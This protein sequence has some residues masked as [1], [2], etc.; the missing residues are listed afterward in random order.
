MFD[1]MVL[2][3]ANMSAGSAL[4]LGVTPYV[5]GVAVLW[6]AA[7][8]TF[9]ISLPLGLAYTL[10]SMQL[11]RTG[12]DYVW[13]S[14]KLSPKLSVPVA[15]A[16][17]FNM[18]TY[19][20]LTSYFW[21]SSFEQILLVMFK[22]D[23]LGQIPSLGAVATYLVAAIP[24]MFLVA[25]NVRRPSAVSRLNTYLSIIACFAVA[26]GTLVLY[27]KGVSPLSHSFASTFSLV[28]RLNGQPGFSGTLEA[29][30][31]L[32]AFSFIW[33]FAGPAVA[34]EARDRKALK[35]NVL[36]SQLLT[37]ALIGVPFYLM[38]GPVSSSLFYTGLYNFWTLAMYAAGPGA[39]WILAI[40]LIAW[41]ILELSMGILVFSR[42]ILAM[43]L[44]RLLPEL[45]GQINSRG[46][47]VPAHLLDLLLTLSFLSVPL[48][49]SVGVLALYD[50]LPLSL[51]YMGLV[52]I[53]AT[54][55]SG[56]AVKF[57]GALSLPLLSYLGWAVIMSPYLGL[58][59]N[60]LWINL[61][62]LV[63]LLGLGVSIY[64][65]ARV[66][67]KKIGVQLDRIYREVPPS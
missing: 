42:Y 44:D 47:P 31:L 55:F 32:S 57:A 8:V 21:S 2:N 12:G 61:V 62:Y 20:A 3:L 9:L 27:L 40:G 24:F 43:A 18:P 54:K 65:R 63:S 58:R 19:F 45:L 37:L 64:L 59:G 38:K 52:A 49:S 25:I 34:A 11:P 30:P 46:S 33:V 17:T 36:L 51:V 7:L 15:V 53:A 10:M 5:G 48:V 66:K 56:K 4:F 6:M 67:C 50:F 39:G 35:L 23:G 16:M 1:L 28:P 60:L 26:Y 22:I 14:R 41:E 13:I 29:V